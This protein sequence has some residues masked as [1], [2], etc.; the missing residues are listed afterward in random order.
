MGRKKHVF[1][2][3]ALLFLAAAALSLAGALLAELALGLVY[4]F[5]NRYLMTRKLNLS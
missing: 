5:A 2:G 1:I 3:A 4:F